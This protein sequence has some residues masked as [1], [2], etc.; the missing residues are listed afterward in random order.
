[1]IYR[2]IMI[3]HFVQK[4]KKKTLF[5]FRMRTSISKIK[6]HERTILLKTNEL[7]KIKIVHHSSTH[8]LFPDGKYCVHKC[9][10]CFFQRD[11]ILK[12]KKEKNE[13]KVKKKNSK[14]V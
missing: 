7:R 9:N 2:I 4:Y 6:N 14:T 13:I 3:F 12:F 11:K 1:M 10:F 5:A 8:T